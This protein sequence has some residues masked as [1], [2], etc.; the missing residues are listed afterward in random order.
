MP[1]FQDFWKKLGANEKFVMYGGA[2]VIVSFLVGIASQQ[3]SSTTDLFWPVLIA[4]VYFLKYSSIKIPWP[5]PT[6]LI[7]L[8]LAGA[9]AVFGLLSVLGL[10]PQVMAFQLVGI[11]AAINFLGAG[12]MAFFAYREYAGLA[13]PAAP[14]APTK[15]A[16]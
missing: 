9:A 11:A 5:V 10:V 15:P 6:Q 3:R 4:V 8:G 12:A 1:M 16:A 2:A 14:K 13:K 7:V